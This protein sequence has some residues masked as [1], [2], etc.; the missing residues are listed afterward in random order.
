MLS[1]ISRQRANMDLWDSDKDGRIV[2]TLRRYDDPIWEFSF[3]V[4]L[5]VFNYDPASAVTPRD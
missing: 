2:K 1:Q 3:P 5:E 4:A